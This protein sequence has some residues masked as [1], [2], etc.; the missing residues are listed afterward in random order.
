MW[1]S[2][3][4]NHNALLC[5]LLALGHLLM[6]RSFEIT[7][8]VPIVFNSQKSQAVHKSKLSSEIYQDLLIASKIKTIASCLD[9]KQQTLTKLCSSM[10]IARACGEII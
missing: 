5:L 3:H 1:N 4:S 8:K 9:N 6:H 7:S 2:F 10:S